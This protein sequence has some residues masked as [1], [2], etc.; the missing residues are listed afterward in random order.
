MV[1]LRCATF[2]STIQAARGRSKLSDRQSCSRFLE[3]I[4][5]DFSNRD[6][7]FKSTIVNPQLCGNR[8]IIY[9]CLIMCKHRY[10]YTTHAHTRVHSVS[11]IPWLNYND[12]HRVKDLCKLRIRLNWMH[13][14]QFQCFAREITNRFVVLYILYTFN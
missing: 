1:S 11:A 5:I 4:C 8:E 7:S 14:H 3:S 6:A 13:C 10:I 12:Q 2:F 9:R